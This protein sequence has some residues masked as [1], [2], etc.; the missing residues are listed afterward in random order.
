MRAATYT[1]AAVAGDHDAAECGVYFFG[2]GQGGSIEANLERWQ[3][4]F[5]A[6]DGKPAVA[7]LAKRTVHGLAVTTIDTTG[8]YSGMGGPMGGGPEKS[9]YRL[10][11]AIIEGPGGHIFV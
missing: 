5:H 10:L 8:Q 9:G 6:A 4:Q 11:G 3:G 7:H 2:A 1:A